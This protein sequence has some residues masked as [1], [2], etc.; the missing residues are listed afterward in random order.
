M[1]VKKAFLHCSYAAPVLVSTT[2]A[3]R[4]TTG[5]AARAVYDACGVRAPVAERCDTA[6]VSE[7][8]ATDCVAARADVCLSVAALRAD[9]T[10]VLADGDFSAVVRRCVVSDFVRV[11]APPLRT[12]AMA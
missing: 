4:A 1:Q 7:R 10:A 6:G 11:T 3:A 9:S 8:P 2:V 5:V 12:A